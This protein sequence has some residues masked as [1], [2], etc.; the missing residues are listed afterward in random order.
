MTTRMYNVV[1]LLSPLLFWAAIN[2][3]AINTIAGPGVVI[4]NT[5]CPQV[6]IRFN[7][8]II[9]NLHEPDWFIISKGLAQMSN[10]F[11]LCVFHKAKP[12]HQF[13][14]TIIVIVNV[15]LWCQ[16][17]C[18]N[19]LAHVLQEQRSKSSS[20]ILFY[21]KEMSRLPIGILHTPAYRF[22]RLIL[23]KEPHTVVVFNQWFEE[24]S[25]SRWIVRVRPDWGNNIRMM[26]FQLFKNNSIWVCPA[27]HV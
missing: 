3:H 26:L 12:L 21:Y 22:V 23:R 5:L 1:Y 18:S 27:T 8:M 9:I 11:K 4:T 7:F 24:G 6:N 20:S 19:A 16:P 14:A 10:K 2:L 25:L 17:F 13:H 15:D